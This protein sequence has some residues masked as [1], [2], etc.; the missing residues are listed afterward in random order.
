MILIGRVSTSDAVAGSVRVTFADR[1]DMVSGELPVITP[2]GWGRGN[3]IPLPGERVL[4]VFLDN[5]RSAGFCL[6]TYFAEDDP[7]SG[8]KDQ[9]G[10]WFEDGSY[11]YYDR[12]AKR[13]N[14][15][16]TGGMKIEGDLTVTGIVSADVFNTKGGV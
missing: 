5:G 9:R 2:G 13:L 11:V 12:T 3:A 7:P 16:G 6:G 4:C 15:K 8:T 1:D 10:V 14:I